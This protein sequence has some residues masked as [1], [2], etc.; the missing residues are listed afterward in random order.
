MTIAQIWNDGY[1]SNFVKHTPISPAL[2]ASYLVSSM[3][4]SE[5]TGRVIMELLY[6]NLIVVL[7]VS[8]NICGPFY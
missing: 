1:S 3:S 6:I 8:F 7:S 4:I 2:R 5:K